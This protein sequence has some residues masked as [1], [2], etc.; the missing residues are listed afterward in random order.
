MRI[1]A[2]RRVGRLEVERLG[3]FDLI[4]EWLRDAHQWAS[5][6]ELAFAEAIDDDERDPIAQFVERTRSALVASG[7]DGEDRLGRLVAETMLLRTMVIELEREVGQ[8]AK[9]VT[10]GLLYLSMVR[11]QAE[12][13][14]EDLLVEDWRDPATKLVDRVHVIDR[15]IDLVE[16]R[17]F[18]G[19]PILFT[20]TVEAWT[21]TQR[22]AEVTAA[23][24]P[25]ATARQEGRL[26][27]RGE[28][29]YRDFVDRCRAVTL[30]DLGWP[31][32]ARRDPARRHHRSRPSRRAR[33][34]RRHGARD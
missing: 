11:S 22:S 8:A 29:A 17:R 12:R 2:D 28:Y 30:D 18:G 23:W 5:L 33:R 32:L 7:P 10:L 21:Q 1:D 20:R 9:Q 13:P 19:R 26:A 25:P 34:R 15:L 3:P 4:G 14:D 31:D 16:R 24:L 6:E 27:R